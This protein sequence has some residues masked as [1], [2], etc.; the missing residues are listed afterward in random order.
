MFD[1]PLDSRH[2]RFKVEINDSGPAAMI[3]KC[4]P[5]IYG[6]V[7]TMKFCTTENILGLGKLI[8]KD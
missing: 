1:T 5:G 7:I 4:S 3:L 8:A 6:Q 2:C